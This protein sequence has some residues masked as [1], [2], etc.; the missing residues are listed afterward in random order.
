M[1]APSADQGGDTSI[2]LEG[3]ATGDG[4]VYQAARDQTINQMV[5]PAVA[6]RPVEQVGSEAV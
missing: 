2:R 1:N 6:L 5:L 4:R 3:T